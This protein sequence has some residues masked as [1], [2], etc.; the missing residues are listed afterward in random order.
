[1]GNV[2]QAGEGQAP[3]RQA[4][5]RAGLPV[6]TGAVTLNKVCGSG[7]K[8][9]MLASALLRAGDGDLYVAG[10]MENMNLA[11]YL[12][13]KARFGYRLGDGMVVDAL[14]HDGLWCATQ[15][16]HMGMSAEWIAAEYGVSRAEQDAYALRKPPAGGLRPLIG[17]RS[18]RKLSPCL[19][20]SLPTQRIHSPWTKRRDAIPV[21][22]R[23]P[24]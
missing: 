24:A 22:R 7:L 17:A 23:W 10:G 11:P 13:P 5:L 20:S 3:A 15:D 6:E 19:S 21:S 2:I 1:M 4:A 18:S 16:H 12:L 14:I 9:V 8:T